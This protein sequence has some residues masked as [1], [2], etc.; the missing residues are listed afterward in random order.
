MARFVRELSDGTTITITEKDDGSFIGVVEGGIIYGKRVLPEGVY[1]DSLLE[2]DWS[3]DIIRDDLQRMMN[4][5]VGDIS[6]LTNYALVRH[7]ET[8]F[9]PLPLIFASPEKRVEA[10]KEHGSNPPPERWVRRKKNLI[11]RELNIS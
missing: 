1:Y 4:G 3:R 10:A 7:G 6:N 5:E 9:Y 11:L 2:N 8:G